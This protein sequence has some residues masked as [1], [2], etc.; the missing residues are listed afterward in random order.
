MRV[1]CFSMQGE[2]IVK[3]IDGKYYVFTFYFARGWH[4]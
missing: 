1:V 2:D 4:S 3:H